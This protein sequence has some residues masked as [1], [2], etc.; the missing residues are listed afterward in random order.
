MAR[1]I[2]VFCAFAMV[3]ATV[4]PVSAASIASP[5]LVIAQN[6]AQGVAI[7]GTVTDANGAPVANAEVRLNGPAKFATTTDGQGNFLLPNVTPGIYSVSVKKAGYTEAQLSDFAVVGGTPQNV[8]VSLQALSFSSLREIARV[9]A[10]G[11]GSHFNVTPASTN[12][13]TAQDYANQAQP[14]VQRVL[15]QTPGIVVDHPGTSAT[16]ASPGAITFPSIRGGLG[17]ETASLI[18]GHPLAVGTFG[19]YVT[20]FLNSYTLQST[21][22][23][24]GPGA[25]APE[26]NYAIGG[27][28]NFRTKDPTQKPSG[29][30]VLGMNTQGGTMS[31]IGYST[32]LGK[33]GFILDYAINGQIGPLANAQKYWNPNNGVV[34]GTSIGFVSNPPPNAKTNGNWNNPNYD[35]TTLLACCFSVSQVFNNKNELAKVRYKFSD[36]TQFTASYLGSQTWTDQNGN[37]VYGFQQLFNPGAAYTGSAATGSLQPGQRYLTWQNVFAPVGE[38]EVNNEPIFQAEIRTTMKEDTILARFYGASISR[39]QS[40]AVDSPLQSFD[41]QQ[42]LFGTFKNQNYNGQGADIIFPANPTFYCLK[43]PGTALNWVSNPYQS[44]KTPSGAMSATCSDGSAAIPASGNYFRSN[45][46]DHIKGV[47]FELDHPLGQNGNALTFA[48]DRN[49]FRT[50]SYSYVGDPTGPPFIPDGSSQTQGTLLVRGT[51]NFGDKWRAVLANY[52]NSYDNVFSSDGGSTFLNSHSSHYDGRLGLTFRATP[53][54]S[55]RL[56]MGSAIAPPYLGLLNTIA[57]QP[58]PAQ[59]GQTSFTNTTANGNLV[60]ETSF[61]YDFGGDFRFGNLLTTTLSFDLYSSTLRNQ[62]LKSSYVSCAFYNQPTQSCDTAQQPGDL[63]LV[64]T[65]NL[66]LTNAK[67]QGAEIALRSAPPVGFGYTLQGALVRAYPYNL[68][69]CFYSNNPV[70]NCTAINTNLAVLP[71]H[72]FYGSGTS[73][74]GPAG[75]FRG[76]FNAVNNHAIPYSQA[77]G[78][79]NYHFPNG[80]YA[81]FGTQLYGPNNS[82]NVPAFVVSNVTF[83]LPLGD[84]KRGMT[85]Q[86]S[87]DNIFNAY[88]NSYITPFAGV[89]IPLANGFNGLTNQNVIGPRNFKF[90][91]TKTFGGNP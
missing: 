49:T 19:D 59:P 40:T 75:N 15:D 91:F 33:F 63:P 4:G 18:D 74:S 89:P 69:P 50:H 88:P 76:S 26:V 56:A 30:L 61:G 82:L 28:V 71:D 11:S 45:E 34:N 10:R 66:N 65:T 14:Q 72:N 3:F 60:P 41:M 46:E 44:I 58:G 9:T 22:L 73:G 53:N 32:T 81:S 70:T 85:Y 21:E 87:G 42:S 52:F 20:T 79:I 23:I 27:T 67:Y 90:V 16:N 64:T 36:A 24:K 83:R 78:E 80:M 84:P 86:V 62:F 51:F 5:G 54:I 13:I 48:Y 17:F 55:Y 31:N 43:T 29:N 57:T 1:F 39:L 12:V 47:S 25:S 2:R 7:S 37:H 77:Y 6:A 8:T 38:W 68:P 35:N